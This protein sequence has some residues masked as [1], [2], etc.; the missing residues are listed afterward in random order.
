MLYRM[1]D[2]VMR[3]GWWAI[4]AIVLCLFVLMPTMWCSVSSVDDFSLGD[5]A[6]ASD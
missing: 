4:V 6:D 2:T 5:T 1:P 3:P